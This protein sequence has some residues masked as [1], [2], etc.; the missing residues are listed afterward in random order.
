[1][2]QGAD[3]VSAGA[4]TPWRC[5]PLTVIGLGGRWAARPRAGARGWRCEALTG[6]SARRGF[7]KCGPGA[8]ARWRWRGLLREDRATG[9]DLL[10][11]TVQSVSAGAG[12]EVWRDVAR[13]TAVRGRSCVVDGLPPGALRWLRVRAEALD[14]DGTVL[15]RSPGSV[16]ALVRV[17][18]VP[19]A[20]DLVAEERGRSSVDLT[21]ELDGEVWV[22]LMGADPEPRFDIELH[23]QGRGWETVEACRGL[24][25]RA[26]VVTDLLVGVV[27]SVRVRTYAAGV[28]DAQSYSVSASL[29]LRT[30]YIGDEIL[31]IPGELAVEAPAA[32]SFVLRW[33]FD[34]GEWREITGAGVR[35]AVELDVGSG[36]W[37]PVRGCTGLGGVICEVSGLD[38]N[39][40]YSVRV[41]ASS[42][43]AE[44]AGAVSRS[45]PIGVV[46]AVTL[47]DFAP[48]CVE[49]IPVTGGFSVRWVWPAKVE[50]EEEEVVDDDD[51]GEDPVEQNA[52][53]RN[54]SGG[55]GYAYDG[56]RPIPEDV[57]F[58]VDLARENSIQ[59]TTGGRCTSAPCLV[60][61]LDNATVYSVRVRVVSGSNVFG[62]SDAVQVV[63]G[64]V[65]SSSL[66][67][68]QSSRAADFEVPSPVRVTLSAL[69]V[70]VREPL[71]GEERPARVWLEPVD[72]GDTLQGVSYALR[73]DACA[74]EVAAEPGAD[75]VGADARWGAIVSPGAFDRFAVG[76]LLVGDEH[77]E[78]RECFEM[79]VGDVRGAQLVERVHGT[80]G[81]GYALR[82]EL[83][84][85]VWI[86]DA[87][88][89][90]HQWG[91]AFG[92][93]LS[94]SMVDAVGANALRALP[95]PGSSGRWSSWAGA[96][97]RSLDA[98]GGS[99]SGALRALWTGVDSAAG[100]S[101]LRVGVALGSVRGHGDL[102]A[103]RFE[104]DLAV[105]APYVAWSSASDW[106]LWAS[107]GV[108]AGHVTVEGRR[109]R[110]R[111]EASWHVLAGGARSVLARFDAPGSQL[112]VLSDV[113][114]SEFSTR[115]AGGLGASR[116]RAQRVRVGFDFFGGWFDAVGVRWS[117]GA[118]LR[119][120]VDGGD[121]LTGL[122]LEG[123]VGLGVSAGAF[124]AEVGAEAVIAGQDGAQPTG[125]RA[126][127]GEASL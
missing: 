55:C 124:S 8:S 80:E 27:Q 110:V 11:F 91:A 41:V 4:T 47:R 115:E 5:G 126:L 26:C 70:S 88:A 2:S 1:M 96:S 102:D 31:P 108:G 112:A 33:S 9:L 10:R 122:G 30:G 83:R 58:V 23:T 119:A 13:C 48:R 116:T 22:R 64:G 7:W 85:R 12:G 89:L 57:H 81:E 14:A 113:Y 54:A 105:A 62:V 106:S 25:S 35:F 3:R 90:A 65:A 56:E 74:G 77:V 63:T 19:M 76:V 97:A 15:S 75:F 98:G 118:G 34:F 60:D 16:P 66:L 45:V 92:R 42:E 37:T 43:D 6:R 79:V 67:L 52:L 44:L 101:G 84:V 100:A 18:A 46:T 71:A 28:A 86:E 50:E 49:A 111:P 94:D 73:T 39:T 72:A 78:P 59:W 53:P 104:A 127:R 82:R 120:R 17:P 87:V 32:A 36:K 20:T 103:H 95:G 123:E 61:E 69:S 40:A 38:P 99:L 125:W 51:N 121:G 29:P 21:W 24:A 68:L 114:T 117:P 107:P 93:G 109:V